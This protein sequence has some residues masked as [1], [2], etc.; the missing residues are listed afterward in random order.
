MLTSYSSQVIDH[1]QHRPKECSR[2]V[3]FYFFDHERPEELTAIAVMRSLIKQ[4]ASTHLELSSYLREDLCIKMRRCFATSTKGLALV[5]A[6]DILRQLR[7]ALEE[8]WI[9]L[10][11]LNEMPEP[12][13]L[14]LL[15]VLSRLQ[16]SVRPPE[17]MRLAMFSREE[18]S[19]NID[20]RYAFLGIIHLQSSLPLLQDDISRFVDTRIE[21][22]NRMRKI[23][24][25]QALLQEL[26]TKLKANGEK[27]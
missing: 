17:R 12:E 20:L 22:S 9:I 27:M 10:D 21:T 15:D 8:F 19:R 4:L 13:I 5:D 14:L 24:S 18:V 23:T 6:Y 3:G 2:C 25:N 16:S 26:G 11:G 1:V 7:D